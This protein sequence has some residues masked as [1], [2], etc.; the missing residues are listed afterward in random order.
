MKSKSLYFFTG[1]ADAMGRGGRMMR[2]TV[3]TPVNDE[4]D[5]QNIPQDER[6]GLILD[7]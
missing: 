7:V 6:N 5:V 1:L 3:F 4:L 2:S